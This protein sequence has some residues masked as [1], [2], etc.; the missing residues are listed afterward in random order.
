MGAA[1]D[2]KRRLLRFAAVAVVALG[3]AHLSGG[4]FGGTHEVVVHYDAPPGALTVTLT[5]AEGHLLRRTRFSASSERAHPVSLPAGTLDVELDLG[6]EVRHVR[7]TVAPET[8]S[9]G[10]TWPR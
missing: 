7:S 2:L 5:D 9:L 8:E 6:G 10:V 1:P 3:L 4:F